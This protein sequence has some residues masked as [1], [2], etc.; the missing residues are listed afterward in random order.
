MSKCMPSV[1]FGNIKFGLHA[2]ASHAYPPRSAR[3]LQS[4]TFRLAGLKDKQISGS[5]HHAPGKN[6]RAA[7]HSC[8]K[9]PPATARSKFVSNP[10]RQGWPARLAAMLTDGGRR[11]AQSWCVALAGCHGIGLRTA[12]TCPCASKL[13]QSCTNPRQDTCLRRLRSRVLGGVP[14]KKSKKSIKGVQVLFCAAE[15]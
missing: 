5:T 13:A 10:E 9:H 4:R 2:P 1:R 11:R 15:N 3:T 14:A 7:F 6:V 8:A 12:S